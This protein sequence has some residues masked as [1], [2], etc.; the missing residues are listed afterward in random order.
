MIVMPVIIPPTGTVRP[1]HRPVSWSCGHALTSHQRRT[2][3]PTR[4]RCNPSQPLL[5]VKKVPTTPPTRLRWTSSDKPASAAR[6]SRSTPASVAASS[7]SPRT[8]ATASARPAARLARRSRRTPGQPRRRH[9]QA[10]QPQPD[11]GRRSATAGRP[12]HA[13]PHRPRTV[14]CA[15]TT[16]T[17]ASR[18]IASAPTRPSAPHQAGP[19]PHHF[20]RLKWAVVLRRAGDIAWPARRLRHPC[21][22]L[23]D[24]NRPEAYASRSPSADRP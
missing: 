20:T 7:R 14:T 17:R 4:P 6:S 21:R 12:R 19:L 24:T 22:A 1:D 15:G 9:R 23:P 10:Q 18:L 2:R 16:R 5:T 11:S 3:C 13:R 8:S